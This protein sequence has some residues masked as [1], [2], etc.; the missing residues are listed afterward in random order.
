MI[1]LQ[2]LS[3]ICHILACFFD[4]LREAA[5]FVDCLADVVWC[6]VCT[7]MQTQA[8]AVLDHRDANPQAVPPP[9]PGM[10]PPGAWVVR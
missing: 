8:K 7:Y 4:Q 5:Q 1:A 3:C 2:Y 9:L 6:S 10:Q